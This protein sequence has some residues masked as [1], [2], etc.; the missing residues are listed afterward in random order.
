[1]APNTCTVRYILLINF[2]GVYLSQHTPLDFPPPP[3]EINSSK[4]TSSPKINQFN[5]RDQFNQFINLI[6]Y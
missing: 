2:W 6:N 1:M 5:Q 3:G 4:S